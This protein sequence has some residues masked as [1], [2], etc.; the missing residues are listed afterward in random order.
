[1]TN[2]SKKHSPQPKTR[3]RTATQA[4][5]KN[6]PEE[7]TFLKRPV[8]SKALGHQE[9]S[10]LRL[11]TSTA[12]GTQ[13]QK[14]AAGP[15][16]LVQTHAITSPASHPAL[17]QS[18]LFAAQQ[19]PPNS[20]ILHYLGFVH[21]S[22]DTDPESNYD[23]SLVRELGVGIDATHM[24][25]EARFI[26]DYR[27]IREEGPNAEFRDTIVSGERRM[28]VYVL[29]EGKSGKGKKGIRKGEEICVSYGK[30][31]WKGRGAGAENHDSSDRI[32]ES[33]RGGVAKV[34]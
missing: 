23:L 21:A 19:L 5:P 13:N 32:S 16:P 17:G 11:S 29:P 22:S 4:R 26:N 31:F 8:Y 12:N 30:G 28:S 34:E 3:V 2:T 15:C 27:G 10:A 25:N 33:S 9:L 24:G 7:V 18:G 20:F 1:M 6:W 14:E